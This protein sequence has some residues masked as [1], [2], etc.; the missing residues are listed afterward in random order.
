M[1][2]TKQ[3]QPEDFPYP[4]DVSMERFHTGDKLR[5]STLIHFGADPVTT[6]LPGWFSFYNS[7]L[8]IEAVIK[9]GK[10][11]FAMRYLKVHSNPAL[12][13]HEQFGRFAANYV[14]FASAWLAE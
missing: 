14:R 5:H 3:M 11:T 6:G 9:E 10:G 2:A 13:L 8:K 1:V 7:R 4:L 12:Y